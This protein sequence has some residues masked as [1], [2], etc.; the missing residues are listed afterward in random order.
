[1]PSPPTRRLLFSRAACLQNRQ[2]KPEVYIQL[3]RNR[4][5]S[6][7]TVEKLD[8]ASSS[9]TGGSRCGCR[10]GTFAIADQPISIF[11]RSISGSN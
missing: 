7:K 9:E 4:A 11:D 6:K 8:F 3:S 10:L 2:F 1:M 5:R